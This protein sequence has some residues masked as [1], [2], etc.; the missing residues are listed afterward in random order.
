MG[1]DAVYYG[2]RVP[3]FRRNLLPASSVQKRNIYTASCLETLIHISEVTD[4]R[5][6]RKYDVL[7]ASSHIRDLQN[8]KKP[9]NTICKSLRLNKRLKFLVNL[10]RLP[11]HA[12]A[13]W[14][15]RPPSVLRSYCRSPQRHT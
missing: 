14:G 3:T 12:Y 5:Y 8:T 1:C 7:S 11:E 10:N 6:L 9:A 4:D 2:R 15:Q 13:D